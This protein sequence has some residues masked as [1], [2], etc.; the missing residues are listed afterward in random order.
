MYN[1]VFR[2]D[3]DM[4]FTPHL[5]GLI[6]GYRA[7]I[8]SIRR[9]LDEGMFDGLVSHFERVWERAAPTELPRKEL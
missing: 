8:L 3:D 4:F 9:R 5:F 7:P 2:A 6:K 1:S